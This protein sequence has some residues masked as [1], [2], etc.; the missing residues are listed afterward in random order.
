M[1][2]QHCFNNNRSYNLLDQIMNNTII[3]MWQIL[4]F[5][6]NIKPLFIENPS[7]FCN[8]TVK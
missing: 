6:H 5:T 3:S 8:V 2:V 4:G 1:F 7:T